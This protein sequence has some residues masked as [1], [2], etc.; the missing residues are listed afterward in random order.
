MDLN[1]MTTFVLPTLVGSMLFVVFT[2]LYE[3]SRAAYFRA[4]QLAWGCYTATYVIWIVGFLGH[5]TPLTIWCAK[6]L[7]AMVPLFIFASTRLIA[8]SEF[9]LHW[10]DVALLIGFMSWA[11]IDTRL[12]LAAHSTGLFAAFFAIGGINIPISVYLG[13]AALLAV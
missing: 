8:T 1:V 13:V 4:W 9:P 5:E 3:Q 10:R 7:F 11:A 6:V 12:E 2:Y